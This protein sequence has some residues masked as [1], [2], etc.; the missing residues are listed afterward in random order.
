MKVARRREAIGELVRLDR[1]ETGKI[2]GEERM[3]DD[4]F[5]RIRDVNLAPDGSIWLLTDESDGAL[6]RISR[7]D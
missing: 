5:G 2:V 7:A 6:I 1:D 3:L 4:E